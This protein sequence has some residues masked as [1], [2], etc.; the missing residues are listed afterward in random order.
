MTRERTAMK[1]V[2]FVVLP[3]LVLLDLAGPAEA[4]RVAER[5]VPGSYR[6]RFV[7]PVD[8]VQSAIGLQLGA[9]EPLPR[10]LD[11][12]SIVVLTGV[13]GK[14]VNLDEPCT[15]RLVSWL[16]SGAV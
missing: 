11:P 5:K 10:A 12:G 16:Q 6:L 1:D 2:L 4:F 15:A 7:A 13:A 9:L 8:T 14:S 3:G